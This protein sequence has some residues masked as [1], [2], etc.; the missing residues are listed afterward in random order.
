MLSSVNLR[1]YALDTFS[2]Y[3]MH[4]LISLPM[5]GWGRVLLLWHGFCKDSHA[6]WNSALSSTLPCEVDSVA[7]IIIIPCAIIATTQ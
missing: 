2:F 7:D 5:V 4:D 3:S 1:F 6:S